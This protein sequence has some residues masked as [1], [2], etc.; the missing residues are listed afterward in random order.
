M[1]SIGWILVLI[2][3]IIP[4]FVSLIRPGTYSMQDSMQYFRIYQMNKCLDDGQIPC[5]WVPDMGYGYGYPLFLY[6]SP[7]PFYLGAI[8]E[9]VG[10]SYIDSVK[11]LFIVGFIGSAI[12]MYLFLKT[13]SLNNLSAMFG[14]LLFIYVPV[15]AVQV[16]V[17]GSLSEFLA[18]TFFPW[19]FLFTYKLIKNIGLFN[20]LG[21]G[22]SL[23]G[24]L[25]THNLMCLAFLP[26]WGLWT[27]II[28]L[29]EKRWKVMF[30]LVS[31]VLLGLGLASFYIVPLIFERNY[32]HLESMVGGYFDYRQHFVS[33]YQIFI[34]NNWGFGSS[35]LGPGDD[36]S[37]SIGLIQWV[38]S[39]IGL[40]VTLIH[41][42]KYKKQF[43]II[44]TLS[45]ITLFYIFLMH[46]RSSFLW[47]KF[48]FMS[49]FQFPW[50][51]LPI[52]AF[53]LSYLSA[54]SINYFSILKQKIFFVIGII[55]L[56]VLYGSFFRPQ[57]WQLIDDHILLTGNEFVKQQTASIFDYLPKSAD[58]PPNSP[59][60]NVPE[61]VNGKATIQSYNKGSNYQTGIINVE[62]ELAMIRIPLF[63]FPGMTVWDNG[64]IIKHNHICDGQPYCF[65]QI[66]FSL[67]SG[68]HS[69]KVS[70]NNTWPRITGDLI[71]ISS[72]II[73]VIFVIK[74]REKLL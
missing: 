57:K 71:S 74:K 31:A 19:I 39:A 2:L 28:Y 30:N 43:I 27:S 64:K 42:K 20:V 35:V 17:R 10:I 34:S 8:F 45:I 67:S 46:Q 48:S 53:L 9:R 55:L 63:D 59:A 61:V 29:Q 13:I 41:S 5:R 73:V 37:L 56:F 65:G 40:T 22:I 70:L 26:I 47:E 38:V 14:S 36:L 24:I 52:I 66:S 21:L 4:A 1:K 72:M 11:L 23:F 49:L 3:L 58:I 32:V 12:G 16:Y 51:M 18:M 62:S 33:L 7:G 15:R 54:Y 6:Y 25:I 69:I 50:R 60:L 44:F 68:V